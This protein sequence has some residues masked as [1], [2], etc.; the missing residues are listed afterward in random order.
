MSRHPLSASSGISLKSR[1]FALL[2]R[3]DYSRE[4]LS[5]KLMGAVRRDA[6]RQK[7]AAKNS[8][9]QWAD[10]ADA[11]EALNAEESA[12]ALTAA[13][14]ALLDELERDNWLSNQRFAQNFS[15]R[16]GAGRGTALV[17]HEL[18]QH[19]LDEA[20]VQTVREQLQ[21]SEAQRAREIWERKFG[22]P[23]TDAKAWAKQARFMMSR[24]FSASTFKQV[25][26]EFKD[27]PDLPELPEFD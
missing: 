7:N 5:H 18:R 17:M 16:R 6:A 1:A 25:L 8:S 23:P 13:I 9:S 10:E 14:T 27:C 11:D 24:G 20:D 21:A 3:R 12:A 19:K 26:A 22:Q 15:R 4:E 2:A